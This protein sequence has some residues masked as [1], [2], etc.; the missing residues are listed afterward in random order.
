[1]EPLL[2]RP[3]LRGLK[4]IEFT[5]K[6]KRVL[7]VEDNLESAQV[8]TAL[9]RD[10]G[11]E[12]QFAINGH[13]AL[14]I[15]RTFRPDIV[16][17]DL[18]LP[19]MDGYEVCSRLRHDPSFGPIRVIALTAYAHDEHRIRA[20][21]AGCHLHLVKPISPRELFD[22]LEATAWSLA[23]ATPPPTK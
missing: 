5:A 9:V 4:D 16:L 18:G 14:E 20:R 6:P 7:V 10:M 12:V 3:A 21:A 23:V 11:H 2:Y 15:A 22:N 17:L 13:A 8:L 1:M 19:G